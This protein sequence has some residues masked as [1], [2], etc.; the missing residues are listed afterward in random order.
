MST[1]G[2]FVLVGVN[3]SQRQLEFELRDGDT[4]IGRAPDN[5]LV[6]PETEVSRHHAR[7]YVSRNAIEIED[8]GSSNH[9]RVNGAVTQGRRALRPGDVI[10]LATVRFELRTAASATQSVR[11]EVGGQSG[12]TINNVGRDQFNEFRQRNEF[13]LETDPDPIFEAASGRGYPRFLIVVGM[14]VAF[15]GFG[16]FIY[17]IFGTDP[18]EA[19][20]RGGPGPLAPIGFALFAVGGVMTGVG[21][22]IAKARRRRQ[23]AGWS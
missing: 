13:Y 19:L 7:I 5:K 12:R 11:F 8:L 14:L 17:V 2:P 21:T 9:T 1:G 15:T 22:S 6:V 16:L 4:T 10:D 20:E 18:Q 3:G 23:S